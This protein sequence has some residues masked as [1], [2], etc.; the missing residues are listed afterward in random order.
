MM[1][2]VDR[3]NTLIVTIPDELS[4]ASQGEMV[5]MFVSSLGADEISAIQFVPK[6]YVRITFVSFDARNKAFMSGIMVGSTRLVA[7]E[8]DPVF[9]DVQL[10]HLPVEVQNDAIIQALRRF[11]TVHE[12]THLKHAGTRIRNGTR[13]IKMSLA[14]DIP[15]NLRILRYPCRVYY[16]GQPRPC[17]ICRDF[18]HRAFDCPLR[19]VCRRCR[20][21][22]HFARDCNLAAPVVQVPA[23]VVE[24]PVPV[25]EDPVPVD[26]SDET[27]VSD[28][29]EADVLVTN[30]SDEDVAP[31]A[32][33]RSCP[34]PLDVPEKMDPKVIINAHPATR[35]S[36]DSENA[37]YFEDG[38]IDMCRITRRVLEDSATP[39]MYREC[40]YYDSERKS[41]LPSMTVFPCGRPLL[42]TA[43]LD[44]KVVPR[45]FPG[46]KP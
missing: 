30:V 14:S 12:I 1:E 17:S 2:K 15:V 40:Y 36:C 24:A 9:V 19:D 44:P 41:L 21:P 7:V 45:S 26:S 42:S 3:P 31:P 34:E 16:K 10:E 25:T 39:E 33:K 43:V 37:V 28:S 23:A 35:R 20:Q 32:A 46:K 8:A 11:G 27:F 22:G 4:A 6:C 29:A 5:D 38:V 13:L 18:D